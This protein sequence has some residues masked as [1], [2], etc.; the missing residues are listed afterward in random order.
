MSVLGDNIRYLRKQ[1]N[2]SQEEIAEM[3]GY[4]S[5]TT[6]QKWETGVAEPSISVLHKLAEIFNVEIGKLAEKNVKEQDDHS[7]SYYLDK[8]AQEMA[9][10]MHENPEYKVLFDASR[11]VSKEDIEL[12]KQMLDR[13]KGDS[14]D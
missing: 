6:I 4:K 1:H 7:P 9:E 10:F 14:D 12:V 8:D 11:H 13:F 2:Y 3:L 5:Y